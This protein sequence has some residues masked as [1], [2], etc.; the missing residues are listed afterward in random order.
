MQAHSQKSE[1]GEG[2][3]LLRG[4][5]GGV[6]Q[7]SKIFYFAKNNLILGLMLLKRGIEISSA[8]A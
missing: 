3:G 6:P 1:T 2:G 8:K 5:G 7:R 4:S